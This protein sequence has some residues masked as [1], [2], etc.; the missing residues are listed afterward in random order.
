MCLSLQE[1][2]VNSLDLT[3]FVAEANIPPDSPTLRA[4]QHRV[5]R[6][7]S[8]VDGEEGGPL[9]SEC[10]LILIAYDFQMQS[11]AICLARTLY[12]TCTAL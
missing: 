7:P 4:A 10:W 8:G 1:F 3:D 5:T 9:C 2:P 6:M 12:T 11:L